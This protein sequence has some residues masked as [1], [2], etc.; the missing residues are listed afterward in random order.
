MKHIFFKLTILATFFYALELNV[1]SRDPIKFG[2]SSNF[3]K[4]LSDSFGPGGSLLNGEFSLSKL[5]Y[6]GNIG[7]GEFQN[8]STFKFKIFIEDLNKSIEIPIEEIAIMQMGSF[9]GFFRPIH[10][11]W[12]DIDLLIGFVL[13]K[14]KYSAFKSVDY[15]Y[16]LDENKFTYLSRDYQL[17]TANHAG[18]QFGINITFFPFHKLGIQIS[19]RMQDLSNGAT[20]FFV[21]GGLCFKL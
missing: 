19:S 1:E 2:F 20:F 16:S 11:N 18:Y 3:Y 12:I 14:S 10:K 4:D 7:F 15:K 5:W 21:G 13:G 6:G 8:Q 17:I 9:S